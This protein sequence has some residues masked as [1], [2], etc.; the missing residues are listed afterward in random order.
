MP[1]LV[2]TAG[3]QLL[4]VLQEP[5]RVEIARTRPDGEIERGHGFEIV[6]EH[7]G[8]RRDHG[9]ERGVA[10]FEEVRGQYLNGSGGRGGAD[11]ADRGGEMR[12]ASVG[13]VVAVHRRHDNM[14]KP[15]RG[16]R[17]GH[18]LRLRLIQRAGHTGLHI[19][20]G[21][22]A[23]AGVAHDHH[24]GVALFPALAD[25]RAACLLADR[26]QAVFAH[27]PGRARVTR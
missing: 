22:G 21:A 6:V 4:G 9:F 27:D 11:G 1:D 13:E 3:V 5:Q 24:G 18:M 25:V 26:V 7:V 12:G 16:D 19:A 14:L 23:R 20:E 8:L 15:E 17:F 2:K 10:F